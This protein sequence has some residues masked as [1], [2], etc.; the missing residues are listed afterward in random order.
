MLVVG[1][2]EFIQLRL[3]IGQEHQ[4]TVVAVKDLV[5]ENLQIFMEQTL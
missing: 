3:E 2:V 1:E 4:D 5:V